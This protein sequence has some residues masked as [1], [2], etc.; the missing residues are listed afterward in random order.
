MRFFALLLL[1]SGSSLMA[2]AD[3]QGSAPQSKADVN[4]EV[5]PTQPDR[6]HVVGVKPVAPGADTGASNDRNG[7]N[8][9]AMG[10]GIQFNLSKPRPAVAP[11]KPRPSPSPNVQ[12]GD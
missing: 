9:P 10:M 6:S 8:T 12:N 2:F 11:R 3:D 4:T 7:G 1:L 5:N